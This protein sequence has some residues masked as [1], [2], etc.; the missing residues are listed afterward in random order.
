MYMHVMGQLYVS[1]WPIMSEQTISKQ[2]SQTC[3]IQSSENKD[4]FI[5]LYMFYALCFI[6]FHYQLLLL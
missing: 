3:C 6:L 1:S 4:N 2:V 5:A